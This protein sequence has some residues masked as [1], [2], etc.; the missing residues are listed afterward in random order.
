MYVIEE[1]FNPH[2]RAS[3]EE[4]IEFKNRGELSDL[5]IHKD[6]NI[7]Y[8]IN[9]FFR[10]S[11]WRDLTKYEF[12]DEITTWT[13]IYNDQV[14]RNKLRETI[15]PIDDLNLVYPPKD[16]L[17]VALH[18]RRYGPRDSGSGFALY[19]TYDVAALDPNEPI[20]PYQGRTDR[21]YPL[22]CVPWQ[23][24][25]DQI[26]RL[27]GMYN[28]IEMLICVFTND[29]DPV[30]V[31]NVIKDK[32]DKDNIAYDYRRG[33][34]DDNIL[35]DMFSMMNFDCLIRSGSN[36]SQISDLIGDYKVVI[37]PKEVRWI[38]KTIVVDEAGY[39]NQ[40]CKFI[41]KF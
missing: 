22:K 7:L 4:V 11:Y 24:Y 2:V 8:L 26:K 38:G 3:Y 28:D 10:L 5:H 16:K 33:N 39:C 1:H 12:C 14:F 34:A 35:E 18:V 13:D 36:Y 19:E 15:A 29:A 41:G 30:Y 23:F 9:Y 31:M 6:R 37:Y 32:V 25:I 17:S 21:H 27:S 40:R 20:P